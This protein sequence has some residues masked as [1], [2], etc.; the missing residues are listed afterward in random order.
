MGNEDEF[1]ILWQ[2][3]FKLAVKLGADQIMNRMLAAFKIA[4][5]YAFDLLGQ[6]TA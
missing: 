4:K 1:E 2:C 5:A 3:Q 6:D